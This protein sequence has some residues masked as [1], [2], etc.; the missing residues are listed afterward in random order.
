MWHMGKR[1][2]TTLLPFSGG[3]ISTGITLVIFWEIREMYKNIA[4]EKYVGCQILYSVFDRQAV[5]IN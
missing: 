4:I 3:K 1:T 5:T 2:F